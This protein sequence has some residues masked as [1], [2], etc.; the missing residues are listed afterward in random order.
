MFSGQQSIREFMKFVQTLLASS[1]RHNSE[2]RKS[3]SCREVQLSYAVQDQPHAV[4]PDFSC[5][6]GAGPGLYE[7]YDRLGTWDLLEK[8]PGMTLTET[9]HP[10]RFHTC[11]Q[12][13]QEVQLW[14]RYPLGS[15]LERQPNATHEFLKVQVGA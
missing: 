8:H 4:A 7:T 3:I 6:L 15:D 5:T 13:E 14:A 2:N 1:A 10:L 12:T 9:A 11:E